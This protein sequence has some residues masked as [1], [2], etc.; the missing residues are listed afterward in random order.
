MTLETVNNKTFSLLD[1]N[2]KWNASLIYAS[3]A[4]TDATI[5]GN[6]NHILTGIGAGSWI[7]HKQLGRSAKVNSKIKVEVG[8]VMS[9]TLQQPRKK[10]IVKKSAGWRLRFSLI[11]NDEEEFLTIIPLVNWKKESYDYI[12]QLNEDFVNEC[13]SFLILQAVHC[14]NCSLSMM[15]GGLVPALVCI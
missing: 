1:D 4:F 10:Y 6:A 8:G 15:T 12:L 7:L 14:T 13:D 2:K 5:T 3:A 9:I 11:N